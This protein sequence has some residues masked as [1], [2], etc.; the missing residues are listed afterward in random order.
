ML[1]EAKCGHFGQL[2]VL[3]SV[4]SYDPASGLY[5]KAVQEHYGE[6]SDFVPVARNPPPNSDIPSPF[7]S[8]LQFLYSLKKVQL[9]T[10]VIVGA[11]NIA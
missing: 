8:P 3:A 2:L 1:Q 5:Y 4:D 10:C 6:D 9:L 7:S 11:K